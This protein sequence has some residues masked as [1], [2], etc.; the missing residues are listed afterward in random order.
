MQPQKNHN[1][2]PPVAVAATARLGRRAAAMA[3]RIREQIA[4]GEPAQGQFLPSERE[5]AGRYGMDKNTV[6]RALKALE[7][8]QV[9]KVVPR[10]GYRVAGGRAAGAEPIQRRIAYV[11]L[12]LHNVA[13]WGPTPDLLLT[14]LR[15]AANRRRWSL[16]ATSSLRREIGDVLQELRA[17]QISGV[18]VDGNAPKL[19]AAIQA[20]GIPVVQIDEWRLDIPVD[21]VM[22]DG[23]RGGMLAVR[24]LME[25]G[26]RRLAW[27]G[28][29]EK[30]AS[31][32]ANTHGM[33]R[34]NG[35]GGQ[36]SL[37]DMKLA[38]CVFVDNNPRSIEQCAVSLLQKK[39]R[40]DGVLALWTRFAS[41][42]VRVAHENKVQVGRD[43]HLVGWC[44]QESVSS[45]F[46]PALKG[47]PTPPYISWSARAMAEVAMARLEERFREPNLPFL[48]IKTPVW[49]VEPAEGRKGQ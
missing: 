25:K 45:Y 11:P 33:D 13:V 34:L 23:E 35:V 24:Y 44:M 18:V 19:I 43:M 4:A 1:Q 16:L 49:L 26:C 22:Q 14:A 8:D 39:P 20:S 40:P 2:K 21:S 5:F 41:R 46:L 36:L 28:I 31:G 27:F 7:R 10:H 3:Q 6:R 30:E 9:V 42:F 48:R 37:A 32:E 17:T 12:E 29:A 47:I 15:H 38:M